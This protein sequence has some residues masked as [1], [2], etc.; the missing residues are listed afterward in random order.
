MTDGAHQHDRVRGRHSGWR[1][2]AAVAA[3]IAGAGLLSACT[4]FSASSSPPAPPPPPAPKTAAQR[5]ARNTATLPGPSLPGWHRVFAD[6]FQTPVAL[7]QFPAAVAD[8]WFSYA[9]GTKD[10]RKNGVYMPT[11]TVSIADGILNVHLHT[12][13]GVHMSAALLP[14]VHGA[15]GRE[16]GLLYGRYMVRMRAQSVAGYK[17]SL[18]L[19]PDTETW[20]RDGEID[21][22]EADLGGLI[23]A[24]LH[25]QGA[26][27]GG[28]QAGFVTAETYGPWHTMTLTWLPNFVQFQ[29]DRQIVGTVTSGIPNTPMHPIIQIE[30][31]TIGPEPTDQAA[32]NVQLAW[33]AVYTPSCNKGMSVHPAAAACTQ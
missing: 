2:A 7:G 4:N 10:T 6:D 30:T 21:Y 32:G 11:K 9:D 8:T 31:R 3:A 27:T 13:D 26:T 18:L 19:W 15:H 5:P 28:Q 24:Y 29:L 25:F 20:P 17:A 23:H 33:V 22:P 1:R 12:E 14:I 16:G